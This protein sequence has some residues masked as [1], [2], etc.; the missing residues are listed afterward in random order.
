MKIRNSFSGV[1][2]GTVARLQSVYSAT[3]L[4]G[5]DIAKF[6]RIADTK[7]QEKQVDDVC[8]PNGNCVPTAEIPK[9]LNGTS[10]GK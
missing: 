7:S 2:V 8:G 3:E 1:L 5:D 10:H 9:Q 6:D 4:V